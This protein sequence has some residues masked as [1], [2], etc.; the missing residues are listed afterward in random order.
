MKTSQGSSNSN[1]DEFYHEKE[2]QR[3]RKAAFRSVAVASALL[4]LTLSPVSSTLLRL[5][6]PPCSFLLQLLFPSVSAP[7][8]A[9]LALQVV[10]VPALFILRQAGQ[11]TD[12]LDRAAVVSAFRVVLVVWSCSWLLSLAMCS[13]SAG[14]APLSAQQCRL[15]GLDEAT[16]SRGAVKP[17]TPLAR[18]GQ[19]RSARGQ[20]AQE[21]EIEGGGP[22]TDFCY[23]K[24]ED[25]QQASTGQTL[26]SASSLNAE[27]ARRDEERTKKELESNKPS[28]YSNFLLSAVTS[29]GCH[30]HSPASSPSPVTTA[31]SPFLVPGYRSPGHRD[32]T[33]HKHA[34][35][36]LH[37]HCSRGFNSPYREGESLAAIT[38]ARTDYISPQRDPANFR[39]H[40]PGSPAGSAS[41]RAVKRILTPPPRLPVSSTFAT[42]TSATTT[43]SGTASGSSRRVQGSSSRSPGPQAPSL[44]SLRGLAP[45]DPQQRYDPTPALSS[46]RMQN[47]IENRDYYSKSDFKS[48]SRAS[49][50]G[51][52]GGARASLRL[53]MARNEIGSTPIFQFFG[54]SE[55]PGGAID[56]EKYISNLRTTLA[57][58]LQEHMKTFDGCVLQ[59]TRLLRQH[60]LIQS[61]H[62][63]E[64]MT[65][66]LKMKKHDR[67]DLGDGSAPITSVEELFHHVGSL[68]KSA[69]HEVH[70]SELDNAMHYYIVML[71]LFVQPLENREAAKKMRRRQQ[72]NVDS[73]G[74]ERERE[75]RQ[76]D[77]SWR[78]ESAVQKQSQREKVL[79]ESVL[80]VCSHQSYDVRCVMERCVQ[81]SKDSHLGK[82]VWGDSSGRMR[83]RGK[84]FDITDSEIVMAL[85]LHHCDVRRA[86][87]D[88]RQYSGA[89]FFVDLVTEDEESA[90]PTQGALGML[91]LQPVQQQQ[92][93]HHHH[94]KTA[95]T[96]KSRQIDF[97]AAHNGEPCVVLA[98]R[99]A[100]PAHFNVYLLNHHHNRRRRAHFG[101]LDGG[102]V[103]DGD[104]LTSHLQKQQQLDSS[105]SSSKQKSGGDFDFLGASFPSLPKSVDAQQ[106]LELQHS[107]V[108]AASANSGHKK[109]VLEELFV[110]EG[111]QN[112]FYAILFFLIT[113]QASAAAN[114]ALDEGSRKAQG[115][116]GALGGQLEGALRD[117]AVEVFGSAR[118]P[119]RVQLP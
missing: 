6:D 25:R 45:P 12:Q 24:D 72:Q 39:R 3:C 73:L 112:V 42:T 38:A 107:R 48:P 118:V 84:D 111:R 67:L 61:E 49:I 22:M 19:G 14:K 96:F 1:L 46:E 52:G 91:A 65:N 74:R 69:L 32:S 100:C 70:R 20:R 90:Q 60:R 102:D 4:L 113:S 94:H 85:F 78:E 17:A 89:H 54:L 13:S 55:D 28:S 58:R 82:F 27:T 43:P 5:L 36:H 116:E 106:K 66:M 9:S 57:L 53:T 8:A 37:N 50:T 10:T 79:P 95:S 108:A 93:H 33:G 103:S 30:K 56:F 71:S 15:L 119:G 41:R 64:V 63:A 88:L 115:A 31:P 44:P 68:D 83:G 81:L 11:D 92:H 40:T 23:K 117:L 18:G 29:P 75:Q 101:A 35:P 26:A 21:S 2:L 98:M 80:R 86:E 7:Q 34:A 109:Q 47:L 51:S 59:L 105:P 97:P 77:W 62:Q 99:A 110:P 87:Q 76:L 16:F 114:S 104:A